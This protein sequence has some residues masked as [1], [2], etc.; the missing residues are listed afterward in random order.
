MTSKVASGNELCY[1]EGRES[2]FAAPEMTEPTQ[3]P[4]NSESPWLSWGRSAFAGAVVAVLFALGI[5]NV[6]LYSRWHEVEDG[7]LWDQRAE[8]V[9]AAEIVPGSAADSAGIRRGDVLLAVHG[10][11]IE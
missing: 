4:A 6:A 1:L 10:S 11:P 2:V 3:N 8:G 7:V 9:T 5:A